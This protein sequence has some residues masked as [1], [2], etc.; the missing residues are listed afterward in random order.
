[1]IS[2]KGCHDDEQGVRLAVQEAEKSEP[3]LVPD[4]PWEGNHLTYASTL[5]KDGRYR[6]WYGTAHKMWTIRRQRRAMQRVTM[7]STGRNRNSA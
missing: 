3:A 2:P 6:M 4:R 1:M 7:A 5:Y